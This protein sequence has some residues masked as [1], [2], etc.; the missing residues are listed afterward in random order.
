MMP[1]YDHTSARTRWLLTLSAFGVACGQSPTTG[2]DAASDSA[3]MTDTSA[4]ASA[5]SD[6]AVVTDATVIPDAMTPGVD[7][8]VDASSA[9]VGSD[10]AA[11][12][13]GGATDADVGPY[14]AGPYGSAEGQTLED[15]QLQGYVNAEGTQLSTA[16]AFGPTSMQALRRTGRRFALVHTSAFY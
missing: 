11:R 15:L 8:S 9:D 6:V 12:D 1:L 14:P 3:A 5:S 10:A 2:T 13:A 16:L 7:A 4:D